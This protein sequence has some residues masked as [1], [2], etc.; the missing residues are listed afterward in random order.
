MILDADTR[1]VARV[2]A[3]QRGVLSKADL[4]TLFAE[5]HP[6]AFT[7][8]V[9]ALESAGTLRRFCRGFYVC[10]P[11]DLPTLS[12]R[13]APESYVSFGTALA[14]HLLIGTVPARQLIAAKAGRARSYRGLG[15]EIVHLRIAPHLDFGHTASDGVQWA[16]PEKAVLD[17]LYFH[18]RGRR[19]PFDIHSDID[20]SRLD[21]TRVAAY[22]RRY[23][24]PKF[25]TFATRVMATR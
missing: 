12:Q 22:L 13:I 3:I 14:R 19:Y 15:F 20:Y 24:N 6:A 21:P 10:E 5:R 25:V 7:R 9:R 17:V 11:F 23:R 16:D 4:Q 2:A 18:L 8:R 1:A